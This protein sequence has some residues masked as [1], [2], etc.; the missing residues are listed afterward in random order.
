[1]LSPRTVLAPRCLVLLEALVA[2]DRSALCRLERN[3]AFLSAVRAGCL[4][5]L[6]GPP[7]EPASLKAH[8]FLTSL[9]SSYTKKPFRDSSRILV[10]LCLSLLI[11]PSITIADPA[12]FPQ[13]GLGA[14]G[15][16]RRATFWLR[17]GQLRRISR[18]YDA[19]R[20]L[21][22]RRPKASVEVSL[23]TAQSPI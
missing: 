15:H 12:E 4:E 9:S 11:N 13:D 7:I 21:R 22:G 20:R 8:Y 17:N 10:H 2:V 19:I 23:L 3:F 5:R 14:H 18:P 1:M 6:S 16:P